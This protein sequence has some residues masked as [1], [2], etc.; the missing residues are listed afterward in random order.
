MDHVD[1]SQRARDIVAG[2]EQRL[3]DSLAAVLVGA[4]ERIE[5]ALNAA[6]D[7]GGERAALI[8][9]ADQDTLDALVG[10]L[11]DM[12]TPSGE[13]L[14]LQ[15]ALGPERF[16]EWAECKARDMATIVGGNF[17]MR[18]ITVEEAEGVEE[19][20]DPVRETPPFLGVLIAGQ[21]TRP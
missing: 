14:H 7:T 15:A 11:R 8:P 3:A 5:Q 4:E 17:R 18:L 10:M 12:L 19:P 21:K 13:L 2:I 1:N 16:A 20:T 9:A 6:E